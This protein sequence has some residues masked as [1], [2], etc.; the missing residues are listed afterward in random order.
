M[1]REASGMFADGEIV[2]SRRPD[3]G[4]KSCAGR[5]GLRRTMV[6][7]KHWLTKEQLY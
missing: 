5:K 6:A 7:I 1:C 2:W 3:A 4:V